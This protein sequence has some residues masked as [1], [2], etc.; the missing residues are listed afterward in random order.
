MEKH[1]FY[2]KEVV[3]WVVVYLFNESITPRSV[4]LQ[5]RCEQERQSNVKALTR[6]SRHDDNEE[7]DWVLRLSL[8]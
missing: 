3:V 4:S 8:C 7:F 6:T 2:L 5:Q 1:E